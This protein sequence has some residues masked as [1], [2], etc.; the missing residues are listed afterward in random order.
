MDKFASANMIKAFEVGVENIGIGVILKPDGISPAFSGK[1]LPNI[2]A[3]TEYIEKCQIMLF[4]KL[5]NPDGSNDHIETPNKNGN[6]YPT[7][8]VVFAT[9]GETT[10]AQ[11]CFAL[12]KTMNQVAKNECADDWKYGKPLFISKGVVSQQNTLPLSH[13]LL[14]EECITVIKRIYEN[15]DTKDEFLNNEFKDD[16]LETIF[17]NVNAGNE[18]VLEMI[19]EL[20]NE[21]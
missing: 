8:L 12:A 1:I 10:L 16:I 11:A 17:G 5:R 18:V 20:F 14:N 13:Y 9:N 2:E 19:D 4:S 3:N 7:D 21:L 15:C 6:M